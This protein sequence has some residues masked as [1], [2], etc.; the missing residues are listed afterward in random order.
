MLFAIDME[1]QPYDPSL[2]EFS[3]QF[4]AKSQ[5][6][7]V[8]DGLQSLLS[9]QTDNLDNIRVNEWVAPGERDPICL[10]ELSKNLELVFNLLQR[11]VTFGIIL[12]ITTLT[13][14]VAGLRDFQP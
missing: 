8:D 12:P 14:H 5:T 6:I 9:N 1:S 11:L 10:A 13:V 2:F 3:Q 4:L 7:G